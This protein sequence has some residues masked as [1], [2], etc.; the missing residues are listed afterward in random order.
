MPVMKERFFNAA[1]EFTAQ[2]KKFSIKNFFSGFG[3][4]Y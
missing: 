1:S 4:T 3:H 2:I